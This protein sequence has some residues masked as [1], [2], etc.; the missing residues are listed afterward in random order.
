MG[1]LKKFV[2]LVITIS[3]TV[4]TLSFLLL[5]VNSLLNTKIEP[6]KDNQ[7]RFDNELKEIKTELKEIKSKLDQLIARSIQKTAQSKLPK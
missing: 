1:G 7:A 2:P 3:A 5:G 4:V 6:L